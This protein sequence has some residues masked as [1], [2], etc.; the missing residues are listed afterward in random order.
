MKMDE[1]RELTR[2][3]RRRAYR[4]IFREAFPKEEL[5]PLAAMERG[6]LEGYYSFWGLFRD[7]ELACCIC[8]MQDENYVLIDYLCVP[9]EKRSGGIGS[10]AMHLM[11]SRYPVDTVFIGETEAET[12]DPARD[13]LILRRQNLYRRIGA[14]F[15]PYDSAL[16]GVHYKTIVWAK[17]PVDAEEVQRRHDGFYRRT[18]PKLIYRSAVQIP[19]LPGAAINP[20]QDWSALAGED[21]RKSEE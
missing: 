14:Q 1:L 20:P 15:L 18:L 8:N 17:Q 2:P 7:G 19:L 11:M 4:E 13:E 9:K 3:E 6:I 21:E 5:K 10:A 16:F 12:G